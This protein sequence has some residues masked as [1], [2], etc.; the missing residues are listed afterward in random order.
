MQLSEI[1]ELICNVTVDILGLDETASERVR[2]AW[3]TD[4]AP[5]WKISDDVIFIRVYPRD[6]PY[7]QQK[8]FTQVVNDD[9][10]IT[11][12]EGYTNVIAVDWILYGP[13]S[14]DD[15]DTIRNGLTHN[16]ILRTN[17]MHLIFNRPAPVRF[18]ELFNG[19]WWERS[20]LTAYF[21]HLV[22]REYV[23][24]TIAAAKVVIKT[25]KG[26]EDIVNI[27]S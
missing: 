4:G 10:S 3:P 6:D 13:N 20:S 21:N 5:A 8:S 14:Y 17:N 11:Q 19:Q 24:P 15:A 25:E 22:S 18:P 1:E 7:G 9:E 2:I 16:K 12:T 27:T 26:D 23:I